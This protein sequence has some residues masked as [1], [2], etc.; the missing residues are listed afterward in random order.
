M[1]ALQ[2]TFPSSSFSCLGFFTNQFGHQTNEDNHE[3]EAS[4]ASK[5]PGNGYKAD[6]PLFAKCDVNGENEIPLFTHMKEEQPVPVC[7]KGASDVIM[8][9][10]GIGVIWSSLKR[11]DIAW[12]FEKFLVDQNGHVVKRYSRYYPTADIEDDIKAL[13]E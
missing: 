3:I 1:S 12:N 2:K 7:S 9:A 4:L 13:L 5:R 8:Q 11:S 10:G 6:F